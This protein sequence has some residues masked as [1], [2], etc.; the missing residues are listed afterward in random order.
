[1]HDWDAAAC[2][3]VDFVDMRDD[4]EETTWIVRRSELLFLTRV[5]T[6]RPEKRQFAIIL[7]IMHQTQEKHTKTQQ[8]VNVK[9]WFNRIH[10]FLFPSLNYK[11]PSRENK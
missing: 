8:A 6:F 10:Y 11:N 3:V 1:M 7:I 2:G 4:D 5:N 9:N